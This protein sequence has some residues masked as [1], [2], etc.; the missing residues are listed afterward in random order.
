MVITKQKPKID[1]QG[2]KEGNQSIP[3]CT[4]T[5][6]REK[7]GK[8]ELQHSQKTIGKM[9]LVNPDIILNLNGL[10]SLIKRHRVTERVKNK[11]TTRTAWLVSLSG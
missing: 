11:Q 8:R 9:A 1:S 2:I 6:A 10:K 4:I 5:S 7:K 3:P